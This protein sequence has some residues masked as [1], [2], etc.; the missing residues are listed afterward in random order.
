MFSSN[1]TSSF[2]D[3]IRCKL[4]NYKNPAYNMTLLPESNKDRL[5]VRK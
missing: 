3:E 5:R 2:L 4:V 1:S